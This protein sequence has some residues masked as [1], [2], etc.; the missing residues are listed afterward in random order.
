MKWNWQSP[1]WPNFKWDQQALQANELVFLEGVG[2]VVGSTRHLS[3]ADQQM[4][5]IELMS[6]EALDTSEI[7][8]EFLNRDSVQSSIRRALGLS[9]THDKKSKPSEIGI[10][11]MMV[12][13]YRT[14]SE[15]LTESVLFNWHAML[16]QGR[17]DLECVGLFRDHVEAMQIV[18]GPDYA[19]KI[20]FE[21]PPSS[22]VSNEMKIFLEWFEETSM[23]GKN[24]LPALT[25]A[26]IAHLWF[27]CIHPFEDG[28]GRLGR[29]I[30]EKVLSQ[31]FR[32]NPCMT[33]LAKIL[34]KRRKAYYA[35]LNSA[36]HA[37]EIT[38]WL[39]WFSTIAI[40]AQQHTLAY[41][42]FIIHK[43]S[44]LNRLHGQL[45]ARQEKVLLRM[46]KEG[47]DGFT[48]GLSAANYISLTGAT[49]AT[50]TRDLNDLV[51]MNAL[52]RVGER[53]ATRY[54]LAFDKRATMN[55][56]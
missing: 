35:A 33:S 46:L 41:I 10:A 26:G 8:G 17:Q 47:P 28:N 48:G 34:L 32:D 37:I 21:A 53:K 7:E 9:V 29:A 56:S 11:D 23:T 25:R 13:L 15:P 5:S 12:N 18:S 14:W 24:P 42:N 51:I 1:E 22:R 36:S 54:F 6:T 44:L 16:M 2:T 20:H 45:N 3:L 43:A 40:E 27:E 4:L 38:E 19:R 52:N 55:F 31:R 30:A 50:T 39:L 49:T